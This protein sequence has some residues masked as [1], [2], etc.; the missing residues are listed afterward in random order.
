LP[1]GSGV[2]LLRGESAVVTNDTSM[3]SAPTNGVPPERRA[4][5]AGAV[6][7]DSD[8]AYVLGGR[9]ESGARSSRIDRVDRVGE[10]E[11]VSYAL[12]TGR[13]RAGVL[14]LSP[15]TA[16]APPRY[17]V[18]GGQDPACE[19]CA[20]LEQWSPGSAGRPVS[21]ATTSIGASVDRRTEFAAVCVQ[22][23]QDPKCARVLVLGGVDNQTGLLATQ[24]V[25]IDG[26]C[27][28]GLD[29]SRCAV[30]ERALLSV[31][32]RGLRAAL[33]TDGRRV[34]VTGG[35]D[36]S[37]EPVYTVD[38]IDAS[39]VATLQRVDGTREITNADPAVLSMADGSVMIAGGI[40]RS[41]RAPSGAV[42]FVRGPLAPLAP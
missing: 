27:L 6:V 26:E 37:G 13:A 30:S 32:R 40:D 41:T 3:G 34:V 23:A 9:S 17:L 12:A 11:G 28:R 38:V 1:E 29:P 24:D 36:A 42:W 14:R 10:I 16:S 4:L 15:R 7:V 19:H 25:L 2:L 21:T 18:Y 35:A 33:A 39:D 5:R 8:Y 22:F 20:A 31:R